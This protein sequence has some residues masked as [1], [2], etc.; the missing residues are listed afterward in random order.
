VGTV[1]NGNTYPG[2][3]N[4]AIQ[5]FAFKNIGDTRVFSTAPAQSSAVIS[6]GNAFAVNWTWDAVPGAEGYRILR[7]VGGFGFLEGTDVVTNSLA[8]TNNAVW[9][10]TVETIPSSV[11]ISPSYQWNGVGAGNTN[12]PATAWGILE[13]INFAIVDDSGSYDIYIDDIQNGDTVFQTFETVPSGSQEYG[14]RAPGFSGTTGPLLL[15][16][17]VPRPNLSMVTNLTANTGTNSVNVQFQWGGTNISHWVRLTT[18]TGSA[19]NAAN[20]LVNLDDPISFRMLLLPVGSVVTPPVQQ[21]TIAHSLSGNQ[22]TLTWTGTFNLQSKTNLSESAW[23]NVGVS[24]S[25]FNTTV[26]GAAKFY[27]LQTP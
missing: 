24:N 10:G 3:H 6:N 23:T 19:A 22:L 20:P 1:T 16:S 5:V 4:V 14:F 25:P 18:S 12:G 27:R 26:T 9:G 7:D 17:P 8:D 21:P 13:S 11:N 2:T 15:G